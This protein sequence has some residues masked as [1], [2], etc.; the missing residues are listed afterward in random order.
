MPDPGAELAHEL[1]T[2]IAVIAGYAELLAT[3]DDDET[4]LEAAEQ[5][6]VAARRLS[7]AVDSLFPSGESI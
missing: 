3:R 2:P 1:K 4:R 6:L 7:I 5:I